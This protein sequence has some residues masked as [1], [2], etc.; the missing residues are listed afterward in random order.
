MFILIWKDRVFCLLKFYC[1]CCIFE[2]INIK[3]ILIIFIFDFMI[4]N[5]YLVFV[6]LRDF[7]NVFIKKLFIVY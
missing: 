5:K 2:L 7:E 4:I 1:C 6:W 3:L